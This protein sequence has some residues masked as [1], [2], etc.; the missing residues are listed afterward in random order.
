MKFESENRI[1]K[2][3]EKKKKIWRSRLCHISLST[4]TN[5]FTELVVKTISEFMATRYEISE[6][7]ILKCNTV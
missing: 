4:L 5:K 6:V 1:L 2:T 7:L 3:D